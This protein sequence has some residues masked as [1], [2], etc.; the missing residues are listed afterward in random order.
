M[1]YQFFTSDPMVD[2]YNCRCTELTYEDGSRIIASTLLAAHDNVSNVV[3]EYAD[4]LAWRLELC[5]IIATCAT[6]NVAAIESIVIQLTGT[7]PPRSKLRDR[8][9]AFI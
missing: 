1:I 7:L 3:E 5:H 4:I 2:S 6:V 9:A 8:L